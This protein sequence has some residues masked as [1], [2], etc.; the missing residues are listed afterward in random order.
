MTPRLGTAASPQLTITT[1]DPRPRPRP[2]P[3]TGHPAPVKCDTLL[4]A[5][6]LE[7][8]PSHLPIISCAGLAWT[9][10]AWAGSLHKTLVLTTATASRHRVQRCYQDTCVNTGHVSRVTCQGRGRYSSLS[11]G[12]TSTGAPTAPPLLSPAITA[13]TAA[14]NPR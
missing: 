1:L 9:R 5:W 3:H 6:Q 4:A 14:R 13:V 7:L 12:L 8:S 10:L 11:S 2:A